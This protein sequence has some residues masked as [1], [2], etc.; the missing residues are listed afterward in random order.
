[1]THP[2]ESEQGEVPRQS[3]PGSLLPVW[4]C[5]PDHS[6][7]RLGSP[8]VVLF[9]EIVGASEGNIPPQHFKPMTNNEL[10]LDQLQAVTGGAI[11]AFLIMKAPRD[12]Y[13]TE[14]KVPPRSF[15]NTENLFYQVDHY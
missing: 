7:G 5:D 12:Q 8:L 6:Y 15:K 13:S 3:W 11:M 10:S 1:M 9:A 4:A 2:P 14:C